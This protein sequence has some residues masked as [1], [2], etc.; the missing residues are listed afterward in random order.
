MSVLL[1]AEHNNKEIRPFTLNAA[2]AASQMDNDVHVIIIGHN[3]GDA[4]KAISELPIIKKVIQ[5]EAPYY[6]NFVAENFSPVIVNLAEKYSHI[7]CSANTFGKNLMPRI[8]AALDTS[9]ISDITKVISADTFLRPI[10]AGNAF[11]TVKSK[12][13][14]KCVTIRPTSFDAC[15]NSGGSAPIEKVEPSGEFGHTKFIKR[16]EIKSDRPELGTARVVVSGGRGMQSGDN[17]KLITSLADKLNAAIGASRAAVDA[18][19][20]SNDHQVGQTGKVVVPDLYIAVG[21]SGAIQHL[22]GMKESKVIVAI[23][24]DGEAPIFS[25]ADYGLEA[26]LFEAL[27]Q[28]LEELNKLNTIQK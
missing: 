5:V 10:Y 11:A 15:E 19:Y 24:K 22:A 8:A 14:K 16:E 12:D 18:G 17:F 25:V 23:N 2:T 13:T 28:F 6:E 3:C 26:D 9:Q 1:I 7:V 21:I 20:I 4:A 27:P